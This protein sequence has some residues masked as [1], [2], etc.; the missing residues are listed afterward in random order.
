MNDFLAG[1][2][3]MGARIRAF[4]WTSTPLGAP[5]GWPQALKTAVRLLLSTGH[6]MFMWWG[7]ELIQFYNDAYR[8]SI[9]PERHPSALGQ[10][11]RECWEEIWPIIG[12]QIER[13]MAGEGFTWHENQLVPITR[14]G[15]REDV[16]WTYSYGPIDEPSAPHGVG[17]VLVVCTETTEQV[18]AEQR[19]KA[20]EARWRALFTQTPG[21]VATL[22]GPEHVFEFANPGYL[23]LVGGRDILGKPIREALPEVVEQGFVELL[24]DVYRTGRPHSGYATP[25]FVSHGPDGPD[26]HLYL[27]FVY[28]PIRDAGGAVTGVFVNGHDVTERVR[29]SQELRDEDRRKDEFLAMLGHELRNP[30]SAIQNAGELLVRTARP[31]PT[32]R[33][34][35]ELLTRQVGHL[36]KLVND[37]LD[38]SRIQQGRIELEREPFDLATAVLLAL[39]TVQPQMSAKRHEV[40]NVSAGAPLYVE[41]DRIRIVQ[42]IGNVLTNAA[43]YTSAGGTIRV[44]A[45]EQ[46]GLAVVE[47]SDNG[48]GIEPELLPRVFDLFVQGVRSADRSGGGLGIGLSLVRRLVEMH[49]G[50]VHAASAGEARGATFTLR[51]PLM[52]AMRARGSATAAQVPA[53]AGAQRVLVVD[54][55]EDAANTL[56][57]LLRLTGHD[58]ATAYGA[59]EGIERAT[60]FRADVVLLDIG[61]PEMDGYEVARQIRA[62]AGAAPALVAVTGYGQAADV[63]RAKEA[64]FDAHLTKPVAFEEL[65]RVL[66]DL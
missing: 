43:R 59:R 30:L 33:M 41:G 49:G 53:A 52:P 48:I 10:R 29:A 14:Y 38:V 21:F 42:A 58:T 23:A 55:N 13:V 51:L 6:P 46:H 3:D 57:E 34:V 9:G 45:R 8:R 5:E 24:D 19:L 36:G 20:A 65:Q 32:S 4:D 12:P 28:Q 7:P 47:V 17:G 31:D 16:Y 63:E 50:D 18:L 27:D 2:G 61:L 11:G 15:K 25:V 37:L 64:G 22:T 66:A 60:E 62:R 39:E 1:G 35:G 56:A 40:I 44:S 54:D 26:K